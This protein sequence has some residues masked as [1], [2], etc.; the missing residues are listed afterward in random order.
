M[1]RTYRLAR[2]TAD[3]ALVVL[4]GTV[5]LVAAISLLAPLA[6]LHP[7]VIRGGSMEP[8]VPRGALVLVT[9]GPDRALATGDVVSFREPNGTV[10]THR[11][12]DI[13]GPVAGDVL[14]TTKGD[15]NTSI[16]PAATPAAHVIGRVAVALPVLGFV[17]AMLTMPSGIAAIVLLALALL[18]LSWLLAELAPGPCAA[19][20]AERGRLA[21]GATAGT[22]EAGATA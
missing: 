19:C 18:V 11:I 5:G 13:G 12:A 7:F 14:L 1:D 16:D 21:L 6:G 20:A 15:A 9:D 8:A 10:V 3:A 17:S 2:R 22:D 4:V